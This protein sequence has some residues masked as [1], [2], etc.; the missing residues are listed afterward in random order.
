MTEM[1]EERAR[2][3]LAEYIQ[4]DGSL[5]D[6]LEHYPI[7]RPGEKATL[8]FGRLTNEQHE[9]IAFWMRRNAT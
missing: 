1:T 7:W 2:E 3:L 5:Y 8:F 4:P 9:A 6:Y